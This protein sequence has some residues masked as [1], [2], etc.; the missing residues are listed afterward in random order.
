MQVF[1]ILLDP[2]DSQIS[3]WHFHFACGHVKLGR[4]TLGLGGTSTLTLALHHF[5]PLKS[6]SFNR[7]WDILKVPIEF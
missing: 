6:V 5:W 4:Q 7:K 3:S 1:D 2:P